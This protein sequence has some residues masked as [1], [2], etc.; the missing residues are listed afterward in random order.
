MYINLLFSIF[1][2]LINYS[3]VFSE[4]VTFPIRTVTTP[5]LPIQTVSVKV[6]LTSHRTYPSPRDDYKNN[7]GDTCIYLNPYMGYSPHADATLLDG[8]RAFWDS[9]FT[10]CKVIKNYKCWGA[11]DLN[12]AEITIKDARSRIF[13]IGYSACDF[14]DTIMVTRKKDSYAISLGAMKTA[15]YSHVKRF[16][17]MALFLL[18]EYN[19]HGEGAVDSLFGN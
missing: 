13:H 7:R 1:I 12:E 8:N 9:L 15:Y 4:S 3:I 5:A 6:Y 19:K 14:E 17:D 10:N 2:L 18:N 11:C 16:F